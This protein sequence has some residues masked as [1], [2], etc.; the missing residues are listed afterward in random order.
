MDRSFGQDRRP[1]A[2]VV[3][4]DGRRVQVPLGEPSPIEASLLS[5]IRSLLVGLEGILGVI[6]G[7]G[8][9]GRRRDQ[10]R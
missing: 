9:G 10:R 5:L 3:T 8:E 7:R 2:V 1:V 4:A 6:A